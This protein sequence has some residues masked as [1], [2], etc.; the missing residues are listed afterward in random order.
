[1]WQSRLLH[2]PAGGL[3]M[4]RQISHYCFGNCRM[5]TNKIFDNFVKFVHNNY[6]M[7]YT[8]ISVKDTRENL[9]DIIDRA[10]IGGERF[11][12]TKFN[13]PKVIISSFK[14]SQPINNKK[15]INKVL[16][17][18]E[19]IWKDRRDIADTNKWVENLRSKNETRSK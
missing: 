9:A 16:S 8:S 10:F 5:L 19:G 6:I 18:Y 1:M 12:V 3:V 7:N 11:L 13:K 14:D 15:D 17:E 2:P 4:T